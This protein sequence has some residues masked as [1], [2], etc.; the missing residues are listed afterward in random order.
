MK[1]TARWALNTLSMNAYSTPPDNY[2]HEERTMKIKNLKPFDLKAAL[3]GEPVM[4]RDGSKA[5][6]RHQETE[7]FIIG[8][9]NLAGIKEGHQTYLTW[10]PE[11]NYDTHRNEYDIMSM[12]PKT[13]IINGFEVPAPE[14]VEPAKGSA[15][16]IPILH[17]INYYSANQWIGGAM[18]EIEQRL[19][20]DL[21]FLSKEDAIATAKAMLGIDPYSEEGDE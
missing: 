1:I 21:V 5:Y 20:R 9:F 12:Y 10:T 16:Y 18:E 6:V 2:K 17:N 8:N 15:Y 4:L 13:R 3:N 11:G 19:H 14:E 7:T